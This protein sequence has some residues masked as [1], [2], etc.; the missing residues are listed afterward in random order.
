MSV[1]HA[2]TKPILLLCALVASFLLSP[3][4][5]AENTT[6]NRATAKQQKPYTFAILSFRAKETSRKRWQPLIDHLQQQLPN[7]PLQLRVYFYDELNLAVN[8][9]EVDFVLTQPAN[10]VLLA[11][12]NQ[13]SSPLASLIN[14]EGSF[15]TDKFGGVIFTRANNHQI[16]DI[17]QLK[18]KVIATSD[19]QSLGSYQ[20]QAFELLEHGINLSKDATLLETGQPQTLA[21]EAVLSGK[22]DVGF[23]RTGVLEHM[24]QQ[25]QLEWHRIKLI[26]AQKFADFPFLTS[27]RLYP[28]WPVAVMP[29]VDRQVTAQ[30]ASALLAIPHHSPLTQS[31]A[32][33]G[34]TIPGDYRTVDNLM[35]QLR[36]EPFNESPM[37]TLRDIYHH[38]S[39]ELIALILILVSLMSFFILLLYRRNRSLLKAKRHLQANSEQLRKLQ[40]AVEQSPESILITDLQGQITYINPAVEQITG[41]KAHELMGKNPRI[42]QSDQT[43]PNVYQ[44][45]WNAIKAGEVW[46]GEMINRRK[47]GEDYHVQVVIAPVNNDVG[48]PMAY[49][50]IQRDISA[51]KDDQHRMQQ[52]LYVDGLTGL[53]NRSKLID[54]LD[55]QLQH[56]KD[57]LV[58]YLLL[59]N[60]DRFKWVNATHG[61]AFGDQLLV[62]LAE[63]LN[64]FIADSGI[65]VRLEGDKFAL[66]LTTSEQWRKDE[67][68]LFGWQ[69][70]L[71]SLVTASFKL[72]SERIN[73]HCSMGIT[74]IDANHQRSS[75][76]I[77]NTVIAQASTAL[78]L[79]QKLG[80]NRLEPFKS[81]MSDRDLEAHNIELEL[82]SALKH[83]ELRLFVQEQVDEQDK[84]VGAECLI[85]WQHPVKGLLAPFAF[86]SVA[87]QSDLI[88]KIGYWVI[89]DA[90]RILAQAQQQGLMISLSVNISPR[91][92]LQPDFIDNTLAIVQAKGIK[93]SSLILEITE[94]LF[95]ENL[96]EVTQKM[97]Q[98]KAMGFRFSID[99][100]GTGYSS[101]SYLKHLPIDELKIDR[102]FVTAMGEEGL[103]QS[104]VETI[105][106]VATKMHLHIVAEGVETQAQSDMLKALPGIIQQGYY[107]S[108]PEDADYWLA[109]KTNKS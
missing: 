95:M 43:E 33:A 79:A 46:Q 66:L 68:W 19:I 60:I 92:F 65:V 7:V 106:A 90:C 93:P 70:A 94:S 16:N 82:T 13:L 89:Q 107:H 56:H 71:Q 32:I 37:V 87:E 69:N 99:D 53:G 59:L 74:Q 4:S 21:V 15:A 76:D 51:Q 47:S 18:G 84:L 67:N 108:R 25:G 10:Y 101:L 104:L 105:Y 100:F 103:S 81:E 62:A 63:R 48:E 54:T 27:T 29:H 64:T 78:K 8:N 85:R 55:K 38:W 44:H 17:Q 39:Q 12:R 2:M 86:I 6:E 41:Y 80:G 5:W 22:A 98:L 23:V 97:K 75:I 24:A 49:L 40:L 20:M 61:V 28:E 34:F 72:G 77:I 26:S 42:F 14:L 96:D 9:Q 1:I 52:L 31:M 102:A 73:I 50:S 57:G 30:V 45:L 109:Q 36:I 11:Y 35:R 58:G 83:N 91:H 3:P 88:I